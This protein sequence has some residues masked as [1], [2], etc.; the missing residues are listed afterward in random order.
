VL[1]EEKMLTV[2]QAEVLKAVVGGYIATGMPVGSEVIWRHGRLGVSPATIR[3]DMA[4]LEEMGYILRPHISAGGVP[5]DMGYRYYV[6]S[7]GDTPPLPPSEQLLLQHLFHQVEKELEEWARLAAVF[8]SRFTGNIAVV[9][10]PRAPEGRLKRVELVALQEFLALMLL[11]LWEVRVKQQLLAFDR[12]VSQDE[13]DEIARQFNQDYSGLTPSQMREKGLPDGELARRAA[14][15]M[16]NALEGEGGEEE[17]YVHGL[18]QMLAQ[19]E[20]RDPEKKTVLEALEESQVLQGVLS[21]IP[22]EEGV[23]VII[24]RENP[25]TSLQHLSLVARRYGSPGRVGGTV[26]VLGPTRMRYPQTM[27]AVSYLSRILSSLVGELYA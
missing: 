14:E 16:I 17:P 22:W 26:A 13:L 4:E 19:P 2:R 25:E 20:L 24:G 27:A 18:S 15:A 21:G 1:T 7:L 6:E 10:Q 23:R 9:T 11:V 5:S 12:P 8:L 3:N